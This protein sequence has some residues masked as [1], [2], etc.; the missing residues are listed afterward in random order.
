MNFFEIEGNLFDYD[1]THYLGHCI[2]S[3]FALG[4]GIALIFNNRY[5]LKEK[6]LNKYNGNLLNT[7]PNNSSSCDLMMLDNI[8]GIFSLITKKKYNQKPTYDSM[9][10][11]L[12]DMHDI[13]MNEIGS[14]E[15]IK[16]QSQRTFSTK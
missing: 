16:I 7:W 10:R 2:S 1:K 8:K 15:K 11:A 3:D 9:R 4:K 5:N 6:L 13:L 12:E 14:D